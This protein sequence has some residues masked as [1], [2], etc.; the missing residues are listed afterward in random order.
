MRALGE[1]DISQRR[2]QFSHIYARA[3]AIAAGYSL[4][5]PN[6]EDGSVDLGIAASSRTG[7]LR[8]PRLELKLQ[9]TS[10]PLLDRDWVQYLLSLKTYHDLTAEVHVPRL[11]MVVL[12]PENPADWLQQTETDLCMKQCGYWLSLRGMPARQREP[13]LIELPRRNLFT[14]AALQSIVEKISQGQLP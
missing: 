1:T 9:E 11:L 8:L 6:V 7:S 5:S 10:G 12:V 4:Y 2:A 3:V 13:V 14:V